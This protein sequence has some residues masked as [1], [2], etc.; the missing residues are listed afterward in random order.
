MRV[1][2]CE[3]VT[4]GGLRGAALPE[5]LLPEGTAMRDAIL[6]DL[7]VLPGVRELMV[8]HD[9]RL[10]PPLAASVP[11]AAGA[12]PWA[13]WSALAARADVIWPVAPETGGLLAAMIRRLGRGGARLIAS[14]LEAVEACASKRETARRLAAAGLPHIPTFAAGAAPQDL[15]W[16]RVTKPDDGAGCENTR[17]WAEGARLPDAPGLI[18]QPFVAGTPASLSLLVRPDGPRLL[19][20]NRQHLEVAEDGAMSLKGLTVGGLADADGALARLA[21]K[22]AA[23][24]PGLAG[25]VGIDVILAPAGPVV[26]EVNPRITTAYAGLHAALSVNPAA[27]LPELIRAGTPP[28]LPHLPPARPV[29]VLL[30]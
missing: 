15:L 26:V 29:E 16:P 17:L 6:A 9:D 13:T 14:G 5:T 7:A 19:S 10:A 23:A 21:G 1:F 20:V 28:A 12:D 2:V 11:V 27:F 8:A 22:V 3:F 30:R 25:I 4:S 18:V 24:F